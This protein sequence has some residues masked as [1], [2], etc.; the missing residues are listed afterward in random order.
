MTQKKAVP[1]GSAVKALRGWRRSNC[2]I[3]WG[4][5]DLVEAH[6]RCHCLFDDPKS[7]I[8]GYPRCTAKTANFHRITPWLDAC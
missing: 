8:V 2:P 1:S 6:G 4:P 3:Q 5:S 7:K